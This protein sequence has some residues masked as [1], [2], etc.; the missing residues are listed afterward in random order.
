MLYTFSPDQSCYFIS[1]L[2]NSLLMCHYAE[3]RFY[4]LSYLSQAVANITAC[5]P[6][7]DIRLVAFFPMQRLDQILSLL[8]LPT[9]SDSE[10]LIGK[11]LETE[12]TMD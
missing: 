10:R 5:F 11:Q 6:Q 1:F 12:L 8:K 3:N 7:K 4:K 9:L 2:A